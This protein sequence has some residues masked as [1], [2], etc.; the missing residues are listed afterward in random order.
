MKK[1][2]YGET[3]PTLAPL[4]D[5]GA[6]DNAWHARSNDATHINRRSNDSAPLGA[7]FSPGRSGSTWLGS[8]VSSHPAV[9]Y[10]FE[11]LLR[12]RQVDP[13]VAKF[14][15]DLQAGVDTSWEELHRVFRRPDP[16]VT[17]PP[18]VA[19]HAWSPVPAFKGLSWTLAKSG[20]PLGSQIF[21]RCMTPSSD[22][23][24]VFKEV[25]R[26]HLVRAVADMPD[27][28]VVYLLR[29]PASVV[30]SRLKGVESGL[31]PPMDP[32]SVSLRLEAQPSVQ[33]AIGPVDEL[34]LVELESLAWRLH[35]DAALG[36]LSNHPNVHVVFYEALVREPEAQVGGV[37]AHLGF[38]PSPTTEKFIALSRSGASP[39]RRLW[40]G[41]LPTNGY[42][43]VFRSASVS[44]WETALEPTQMADLQ[45]IVGD[46]MAMTQ[47][48]QAGEWL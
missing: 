27:V 31:M 37:L 33:R 11:P 8:M 13:A 7:I 4:G 36:A 21:E 42:F 28:P 14:D 9:E 29:H 2:L 38:E 35:T 43:T 40:H 18:F 10:R 23:R 44:P 30:A 6:L 39:L 17:K 46:G 3:E 26:L 45:R 12:L 47:A 32:A 48:R 1:P 41:E 24:V 19:S 16:G 15:Q 22:A 5:L 34:S 20:L 25:E